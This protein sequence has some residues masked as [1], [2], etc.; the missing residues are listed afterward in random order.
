MKTIKIE[1]NINVLSEIQKAE[2]QKER[3]ENKGYSIQDTQ[4]NLITGKTIIIYKN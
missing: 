3:L 1:F 2:K 4:T